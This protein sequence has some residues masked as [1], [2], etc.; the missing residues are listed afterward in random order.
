[1]KAELPAMRQRFVSRWIGSHRFRSVL[2]LL[3]MVPFCTAAITVTAIVRYGAREMNLGWS[4]LTDD[5]FVIGNVEPD[6][7][8]YG[9]LLRGDRVVAMDQDARVAVLGTTWKRRFLRPGEP[10]TLDLIRD[11]AIRHVTLAWQSIESER[12]WRLGS[13]TLVG[14]V[15]TGFGLFVGFARPSMLAAR[16]WSLA[17]LSVGLNYLFLALRSLRPDIGSLP[18]AL[19]GVVELNQAIVPALVYH[20]MYRFPPRAP[21]GRFWSFVLVAAYGVALLL[22]P[23]VMSTALPFVVNPDLAT[24]IEIRM[25]QLVVDQRLFSST[26][27]ATLALAGAVAVRNYWR[28]ETA[29]Q[30]RRIRWIVVAFAVVIVPFNIAEFIR[31]SPL[32]LSSDLFTIAIPA[33]F[34]YAIVR[35]RVFDI[36]VAIRIG[37]QY[38]L[39][40]NALRLA[41]ALPLLAMV[42]LIATN[43]QL[44]IRQLALEYPTYPALAAIAAGVLTFRSRVAAA[45]DRRFFREAY[46]REQ[47]LRA[48]LDD[49]DNLYVHDDGAQRIADRLE[50]AL[51]P[52]TLLLSFVDED[53]DKLSVA[54]SLNASVDSKA[55]LLTLGPGILHGL[56]HHTSAL[57]LSTAEA[58]GQDTRSL[59]RAGLEV[60]VPMVGYDGRLRGLLGLGP[61]RGDEPYTPADFHLLQ[62]IARQLAVVKEHAELRSQITKEQGVRQEVLGRLGQSGIRLLKE[63]P[64]CGS[65]YESVEERCALDGSALALTLPVERT[66]ADRYRLDR[67]IGR[68]GM[69][70]V[71]EAF[72]PRYAP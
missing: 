51:H 9:T 60:V 67:L 19:S 14:L 15:W 64:A 3:S 38:L 27:V 39:A 6:G 8:A 33:A 59:Q 12:Q 42:F 7:P 1:M 57:L 24:A 31:V 2:L 30:R 71:Y 61:K 29:D 41:T 55:A 72:D 37:L 25:S 49:I 44:T 65:C 26:V 17:A 5:R 34:A 58:F 36:R 16:L 56:A 53:H 62:R 18:A 68:G 69:G 20:A 43:P 63:C 45:I 66:I 10:Y 50:S 70:A 4:V 35:H 32:E 13:W 46:D 54:A 22:L 21:S 40:R 23:T 48:L 11:G 47:L 52:A 28:V